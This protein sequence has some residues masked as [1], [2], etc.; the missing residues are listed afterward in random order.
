MMALVPR[1]VRPMS[2]LAL[3]LFP[4][5]SWR[6]RITPLTLRADLL[7]GMVGA[8]LVLPQAVAFATLAGMPPE[9]GL[10]GAMV[11]AGGRAPSGIA[12]P[13][14]LRAPHPPAP[15]VVPVA[16]PPGPPLFPGPHP[17]GLSF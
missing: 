9:Y 17:P 16:G 8:L 2:S 7:A 1:H 14:C 13:P 6:D 12:S 5:L 15:E 4:F 3:K 11:P 10:Y